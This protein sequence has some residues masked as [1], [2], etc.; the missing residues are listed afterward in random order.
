MLIRSL[1]FVL[2]TTTMVVGESAAQQRREV[3]DTT[4][5]LPRAQVTR[6]ELEAELAAERSGPN[7]GAR[8]AAIQQRL[9]EGDLRSG[10]RIWIQVEGEPELTDT[11]TVRPDRT[12]DLPNI[13][14]ISVAGLLRSEVGPAV[15]AELAKYIRNPVV[16]VQP[17]IRVAVLGQ[18]NQPGYYTVAA[19]APLPD[20]VMVAGGPTGNAAL[21]K[22]QVRRT[23]TLV[24]S[25]DEVERALAAGTSLDQLNLHSGDEI[26]I[27][28]KGSNLLRTL[29]V[30][31]S[32]AG[33]VYFLTRIF[34]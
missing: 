25:A 6:A 24:H 12:L 15:T 20:V 26:V 17:L 28:E 4:A 2:L 13:R 33:T 32:A 22:T 8:I 3:P 10:D 14:P 16:F 9:E 5:R 11:F 18:V 21:D 34:D 27:G 23:G 7:R 1:L 29:G 31:G 30:I 19:D